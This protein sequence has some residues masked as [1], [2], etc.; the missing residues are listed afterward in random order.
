[1]TN[2]FISTRR[3]Q[4]SI[5][6]IESNALE[7]FES[8]FDSSSEQHLLHAPLLAARDQLQEK[9]QTIQISKQLQNWQKKW[10]LPR[11]TVQPVAVHY[12]IYMY[13]TKGEV[14]KKNRLVF[15]RNRK[16]S[17]KMLTT[18]FINRCFWKYFTRM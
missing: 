3:R 15:K 2:L 9:Q 14:Y 16:K 6:E 7:G 1:M 12:H 8:S 13:H 11:F 17:Y 4:L 10:G 18:I 5:A